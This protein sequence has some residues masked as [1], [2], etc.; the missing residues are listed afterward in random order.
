MDIDPDKLAPAQLDKIA[1]RLIEAGGG[2][3]AGEMS[4]LMIL[5]KGKRPRVVP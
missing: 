4:P 2:A 3:G 5:D 1:V